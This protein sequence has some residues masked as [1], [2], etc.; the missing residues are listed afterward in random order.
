MPGKVNPTQCESMMM[1]CAQVMGNHS[2]ITF[3]ASQGNFQLNVM[4]PLIALNF[5][6]SV[7]LLTDSINSFVKNCSNGIKINNSRIDYYLENSLMLV[8]ALSPKI[9][10]GKAAEIA[11]YAHQHNLTLK[12]AALKLNYISSEEFDRL[13]KPEKMI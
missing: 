10:Y 1:V 7:N 9:G 2:T 11:K 13:M 8:T 3:A 4:M 6:N 12:Q 5:L